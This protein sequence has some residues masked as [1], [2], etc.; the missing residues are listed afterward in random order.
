MKKNLFYV[1]LGILIYPIIADVAE[2]IDDKFN[3]RIWVKVGIPSYNLT[4]GL[5]GRCTNDTRPNGVTNR[6]YFGCGKINIVISNIMYG[7][8]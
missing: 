3:T 7:D 8:K 4:T 1:L 2:L 5:T 6:Q